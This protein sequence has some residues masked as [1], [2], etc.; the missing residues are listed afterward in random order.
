[1]N[2]HRTQLPG[3]NIQLQ[4]T[5]TREDYAELRLALFDLCLD[6]TGREWTDR[7]RLAAWIIANMFRQSFK[8]EID[9]TLKAPAT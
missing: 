5:I 6:A 7:G 4:T 1:M 3:G 9:E 2:L 8:D